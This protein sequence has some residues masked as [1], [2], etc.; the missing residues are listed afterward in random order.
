MKLKFLFTA[1]LGILLSFS[2]QA[3]DAKAATNSV[4]SNLKLVVAPS[5]TSVAGGKANLNVGT[6][7]LKEGNYIGEYKVDVSPYFFQ[8]QKGKLALVASDEDL[9]KLTNGSAVD[10]TGNA[11][12]EKNKQTKVNGTITP[13]GENRGMVKLWF[14]SGKRKL[15]FNTSYRLERK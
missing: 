15:T 11:T 5:A 3:E 12:S 4:Y 8:S 10:F 13:T 14:L 6:L 7:T 1:W 9:R 2:M